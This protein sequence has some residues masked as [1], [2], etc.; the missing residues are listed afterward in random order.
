MAVSKWTTI[1]ANTGTPPGLS[2]N[3]KVVPGDNG[4]V[5]HECLMWLDGTAAITTNHF[6]FPVTGDLTITLNG[7]LNDITA[8]AGTASTTA[9]DV[10]MEGSIDG[11]NYTKLQDLVSW[12]AGG[13]AVSETVGM[14]V[15]DYAS[16]G[17]LP[18]MRLSVTPGSD[19]NCITAAANV[20]I[21]VVLHN[22]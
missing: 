22:G 1:G 4:Q 18:Y 9:V 8:D 10:D 11:T 16:N 5:R 14:A 7:T 21:T 17:R 3:I 2:R 19:A 15:Y 12:N 20:K 13:G 6:D